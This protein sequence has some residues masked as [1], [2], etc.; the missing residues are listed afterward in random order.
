MLERR[1]EKGILLFCWWECKWIE[2]LGKVPSE[3]GVSA[4]APLTVFGGGAVL[5]TAG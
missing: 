3:P 2:S 5:C 4:S 1:G